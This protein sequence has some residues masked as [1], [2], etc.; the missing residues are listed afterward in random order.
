MAMTLSRQELDAL[1]GTGTEHHRPSIDEDV[2]KRFMQKATECLEMF[3][4]SVCRF[5]PGKPFV[6]TWDELPL[7]MEVSTGTRLVCVEARSSEPTRSI[8]VATTSLTAYHLDEIANR[9]AGGAQDHA[10]FV[11]WRRVI[12]YMITES[13]AALNNSDP[14]EL[15][16]W[17]SQSPR[18][19]DIGTAENDETLIDKEAQ[20]VVLPLYAT[21]D[22]SRALYVL[23]SPG[24]LT[25]LCSSPPPSAK[26]ED[27]EIRIA[28]LP[29]RV[30]EIPLSISIVAPAGQLTVR[31][32]ALWQVGSVVPLT[33]APNA[34]IRLQ[35]NE[36]ALALGDLI[37][38]ADGSLAVRITSL[39][40]H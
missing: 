36:H 17:Q 40:S 32:V 23:M 4:G 37:V 21:D 8:F 38:N 18:R 27:E 25:G 7:A 20:I 35:V 28:T 22:K 12:E 14:P 24:V 34:S 16:R 31:C 5:Q 10:P 15:V 9:H 29:S 19:W 30:A 11:A 2:V 13:V 3:L 39:L 6:S 1:L 26:K 33:L